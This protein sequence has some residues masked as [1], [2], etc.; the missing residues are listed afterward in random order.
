MRFNPI[1]GRESWLKN[2]ASLLKWLLARQYEPGDPMGNM[3]ASHIRSIIECYLYGLSKEIQ[4]VIARS[5]EWLNIAIEQDEW[6]DHPDPD[7]HRATLHEAKALALWLQ[8]SDP[9]IEIWDKARHFLLS[10]M[11]PAYGKKIK[12]DG[13]DAY[14]SYCIHAEQYEAGVMEYEKYY[15]VSKVSFGGSMAPRK[16][17]YAFCLNH[18]KPQFDPEK[19]FQAGRKMLQTHLDNNWLGVGQ[20]IRAAMWLKNVYWHDNRTLTP[21]ETILKAYENMPDIPK[22]DFIEN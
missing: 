18:I 10:V 14:L 1:R 8:N 2:D 12:T 19:L 9:A 22:P 15:G 6:S 13:L 3:A 11:E 5:L 20:N 7:Y 16:W 17:A 4:P 21:L